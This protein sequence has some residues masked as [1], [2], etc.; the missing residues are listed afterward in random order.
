MNWIG[1]A[2]QEKRTVTRRTLH[3]SDLD[4]RKCQQTLQELDEVLQQ[5]EVLFS[6][7]KVPKVLLLLGG[8]LILPKELYEIN[9]ED[10]ELASGDQCLRVSSCLKQLFRTLF[11]ADLLSDTRPVRLMATTLLALAHRDCGVGWFRPKLQFK[12]PTHVKNQVIAL[13]TDPKNSSESRAKD[14]DWQDYVWFQAPMPIKGFGKWPIFTLASKDGH[15]PARYKI[16]KSEPKISFNRGQLWGSFFF[17]GI[18]FNC[19]NFNVHF[20]CIIKMKILWKCWKHNFFCLLFFSYL[21]GILKFVI[22]VWFLYFWK[23]LYTFVKHGNDCECA[24]DRLYKCEWP[25]QPSELF[26]FLDK[27]KDVAGQQLGLFEGSKVS[28]ARHERVRVNF[29]IPNF[30]QRLWTV[31]QFSWKGC[32]SGGHKNS[33]PK[34]K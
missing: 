16:F 2:V 19:L 18:H 12:V 30:R 27:L 29:V 8:S 34:I 26:Y 24:P 28:T 9:M 32:K 4:W 14:T 25:W 7:S 22:N 13:F 6:L 17:N 10:L 33:C 15:Y 31:H 5:L 11:V 1:F 21:K 20:S 23:V 3:S